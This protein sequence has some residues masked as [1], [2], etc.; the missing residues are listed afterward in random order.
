ME[1]GTMH[2][3]F[4]IVVL[5]LFFVAAGVGMAMAWNDPGVLVAGALIAMATSHLARKNTGS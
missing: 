1:L 2:Q 3:L 4:G 5:P